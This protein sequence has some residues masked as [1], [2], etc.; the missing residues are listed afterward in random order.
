VPRFAES[1]DLEVSLDGVRLRVF[2][3]AGETLAP[4][5]RQDAYQQGRTHVDADWQVRVPVKSGPHRIGAT[6]VK[7]SSAINETARLPFLRP[8]AGSGGDTR[9]QPYL[10]TVTITGPLEATGSDDTPSRRRI[11]ACRPARASAE[12]AC[13]KTILTTLARRA[14]RRPVT[15][16]DVQRLLT[17]YSDGRSERGFEAGIEAAL[18]RLLVS[19]NF[20]FRVERDPVKVAPGTAY[21]ITDL[22]L[23]SRLSFFLW[24]SIPDDELLDVA[25]RGRLRD[26]GV[27][28][29]QVRRMLADWRSEAL[30]KNFAA[31]WLFLRNVPALSP[32]LDLFPDFDESLRQALQRETELFVDS[33]LREDRGVLDLLTADYT[34]VNERLARHYGIPNVK[35]SHSGVSR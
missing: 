28:E 26:P 34:F 21:R 30:I 4:G 10:S 23:A 9:Y 1:H 14:Y 8:Y 6:F 12:L 17:F 19:P 32:D 20:L 31:Q 22:E 7:K 25:T 27:L 16:A 11:F 18:T 13:A 33:V 3:L 29:Q 24:S 35:G 5:Q 15:D 2:T